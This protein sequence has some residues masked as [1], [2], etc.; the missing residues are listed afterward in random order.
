MPFNGQLSSFLLDNVS[1]M[2]IYR[3]LVELE[4]LV[5]EAWENVDSRKALSKVNAMTI[6]HT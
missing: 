1:Y 6:Y 3:V 4:D 5:K 2:L